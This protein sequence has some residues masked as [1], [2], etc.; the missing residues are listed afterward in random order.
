MNLDTAARRTDG[1]KLDAEPRTRRSDLRH[2]RG[3]AEGDRAKRPWGKWIGPLRYAPEIDAVWHGQHARR[4]YARRMHQ[5]IAAGL[6]YRHVSPDLREEDRRLHPVYEGVTDKYRR[7]RRKADEGF[8][9]RNGV[10]CMDD[11]GGLAQIAEIVDRRDAVVD[12]IRGDSA[13]SW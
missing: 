7:R 13:K 10:V 4:L 1:G 3:L 5:S 12:E 2:S 6:V 11:V 9:R 8:P